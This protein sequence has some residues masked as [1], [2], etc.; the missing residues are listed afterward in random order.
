ML[1]D[2][3][4]TGPAERAHALV[5]TLL[6]YA[7]DLIAGPTPLHL[8][9]KP[10]IGTGASLLIHVIGWLAMGRAPEVM[11]EGRDEDEWRKRIVSKLSKAATFTVLDN[12]RSRLES[13]ALASAIT[14]E[15]FEDR[16]LGR[17]D[18]TMRLPVRTIWVGTGNNP[19]LSQEMSRRTVRIRLDAGVEQPWLRRVFKHPDL[20]AWVGEH[21]S[22]LVWAAL[23]LVRAWLAAGRPSGTKTLGSFEDWAK[24]MGGISDV[25]SIDGF[26]GNLN[27]FYTE[28]D[29]ESAALRELV[30]LWWQQYEDREITASEV[31]WFIEV[32]GRA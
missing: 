8:I 4:F 5:L 25:A 6:P 12:L 32:G 7:R 31:F 18:T 28:A 26:L 10:T 27:E 22:R 14:A 3:P 21:R 23:V 30:S 20:K 2:F 16:V 9:E 1:G 13:A 17:N 24:V 15:V 29:A 19:T 11:T